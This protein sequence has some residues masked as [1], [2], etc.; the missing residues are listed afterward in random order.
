M[1][2]TFALIIL[3]LMGWKIITSMP[4]GLRK[5]VLIVAPHT[6]NLDFVIGRL[7]FM[8]LGIK[9]KFLIKKESFV[10]PLGYLL[11]KLGGIPIDRKNS[12]N[13]VNDVAHLF[14]EN[15]EL[16]VIITPEGT[17]KLTKN[18]KRGYYYIAELAK[19]P[20]IVSF[21]DYAKK[22]GGIAFVF[23]PTGNYEKDFEPIKE[24]YLTKRAKHPEKFNF[25]PM[26]QERK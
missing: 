22:E 1:T 8:V 25:S 7:F 16:I 17:R 24:L 20:V 18:W 15:K 21:I 5:G 11:K 4:E 9:S 2:K 14:R 12:N 13:V 3:K 10:G 19:V 23:K 26:Y 6:S